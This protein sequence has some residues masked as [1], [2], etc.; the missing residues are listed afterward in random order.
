LG[1]SK[2]SIEN[3]SNNELDFDYKKEAEIFCNE[4]ECGFE[5]ITIDDVYKIK[6][7][8]LENIRQNLTSK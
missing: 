2:D 8:I 7:I 4:Y 3:K 6:S 5:Y 1:Y